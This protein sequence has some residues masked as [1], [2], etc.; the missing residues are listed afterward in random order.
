MP[1]RGIMRSIRQIAVMAAIVTTLLCGP[2]GALLAWFS[3]AVLGI[4]LHAFVTFGGALNEFQGLLAWWALCFLPALAYTACVMP[5]N[6]EV[7]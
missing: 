6:Q 3:F 5:W 4:S 2:V 1:V 7:W